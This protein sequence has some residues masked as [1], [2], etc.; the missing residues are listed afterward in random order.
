MS[1][2]HH[3]ECNM[4]YIF[5]DID[6]VMNNQ[7]D[8]L[9]KVEN[10]MEQFKDHRMFCDAA[11][12]MLANVCQLTGAKVVLSSSWRLNLVE[13]REK[14]CAPQFKPRRENYY[15]TVKLLEYFD[16]YGIELVGLTTPHYDW[17]GKQITEYVRR[18]FAPED[19][20]VVL[21]D[22]DIDM[23]DIPEAQMIKTEWLTGLLPEHCERIVKYFKG[24]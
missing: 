13:L 16:Y 15:D 1:S 23:Y 9:W 18:Y 24:E 14:G 4:N 7:E 2:K 20:W 12:G 21:D 3:W 8:W 19:K 10:D 6:G 17:R 22:E 11:W 5:L